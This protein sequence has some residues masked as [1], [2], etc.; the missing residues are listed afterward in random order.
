MM[1]VNS[2]VRQLGFEEKPDYDYLRDQFK[3]MMERLELVDDGHF[4]WEDDAFYKAC[5]SSTKCDQEQK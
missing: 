2:N 3:S 1:I 4:D 5:C